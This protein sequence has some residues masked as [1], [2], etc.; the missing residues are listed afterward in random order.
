MPHR[1]SFILSEEQLY[2]YLLVYC[3][4]PASGGQ[5][6]YGICGPDC[7]PAETDSININIQ[8]RINTDRIIFQEQYD[9]ENV[10]VFDEE[11]NK[12]P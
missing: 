7:P 3:R 1:F 8:E 12:A 5:G 10:I 2:L 4:T 9:T 11:L 6:N